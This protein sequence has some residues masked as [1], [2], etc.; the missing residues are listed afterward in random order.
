MRKESQRAGGNFT[1]G[2]GNGV[3]NRRQ[4]EKHFRY[5]RRHRR[6]IKRNASKQDW[7]RRAPRSHLE[8]ANENL[9]ES[10]PLQRGGTR[11]RGWELIR[12]TGSDNSS[13]NFQN[14]L[15]EQFS[16]R[17]KGTYRILLSR[18]ID[19]NEAIPRRAGTKWKS[20]LRSGLSPSIPTNRILDN[21]NSV[22]RIWDIYPKAKPLPKHTHARALK[23]LLYYM[24]KWL[25]LNATRLILLGRN[26]RQIRLRSSINL[27][28]GNYNDSEACAWR[29]ITIVVKMSGAFDRRRDYE[30]T[31]AMNFVRLQISLQS[32]EYTRA[33]R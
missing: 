3:E 1:H 14:C 32:R 12:F 29:A 24:H 4:S 6:A 5:W 26:R 7:A 8:K 13:S 22:T 23:G 9:R 31:W 16:F 17:D 30:R 33:R 2:V 21:G 18:K 20:K 19:G 10:I 25:H 27:E 15:R 28:R 11:R